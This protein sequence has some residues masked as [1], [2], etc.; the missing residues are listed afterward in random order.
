MSEQL[1]NKRIVLGV[2][3]SI[4][5][6]KS[7]E[8]IRRLKDFGADVKVVM[9]KAAC[10]FITPLTLQTLSGQPVAIELLD[11]DEESAMGHIKLARW[12][13]WIV[14]APASANTM[15]GLAQG[16]TDDLLSAMC[17]ATESPI[18]I[19]PAMNNK[20]WSHA[21]TQA[22]LAVLRTLGMHIIG[23]ASGDQA[24][25]EQGAGRLVEP[26]QLIDELNQLMVPAALSGK[27]VVITAGPTYEPIDPVRF[28]GNRSS[29]KMGFAIAQAA[30]EA[31]A[32][33]I[34]I[35]GPVH[36]A[37]PT[38]VQR[39]DVETAQQMHQAVMASVE[40]SD[41]FI[42]CAAVADYRP[43]QQHQQKIK[44]ESSGELTLSLIPNIDIVNEVTRLAITPFVVGFA[45]ETEQLENYAQSKLINKKLDMIAANKVGKDLGFAVDSN[46][47]NVYWNN[48]QQHLPFTSKKQLARNLM[49]LIIEQYHAKNST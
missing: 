41:I 25:G 42:S 7:A 47:L 31:G 23:P 44:K 5:A 17:L 48:G 49:S 36:L 16:R 45:A 40:D 34:L 11:A 6:Y 2:S 32:N 10:E 1:K 46:E 26:M 21:A 38:G 19:A 27:Q 4:A 9:T 35:S 33:V 28:I 22:N 20:M 30:Y 43:E 15:A 24:C 3:G 13:D 18:V 29:G 8:I 14:I 39:I 12:A 37:T